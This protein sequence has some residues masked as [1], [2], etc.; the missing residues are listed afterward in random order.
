MVLQDLEALQLIELT[1]HRADMQRSS[2][3]NS[4][5]TVKL[6]V[7][8]YI[9]QSFSPRQIMAKVY[10]ASRTNSFFML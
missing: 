10:Q 9:H 6:F 3:L 8:E 7:L 5:Y 4:F 2:C 1:I